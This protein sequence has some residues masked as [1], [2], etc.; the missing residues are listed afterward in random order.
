M[1]AT[2]YLKQRKRKKLAWLL[3]N[4]RMK[5]LEAREEKDAAYSIVLGIY[6]KKRMKN[7]IENMRD[8]RRE[9][10]RATSEYEESEDEAGIVNYKAREKYGYTFERMKLIERDFKVKMRYFLGAKMKYKELL[11]NYKKAVIKRKKYEYELKKL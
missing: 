7:L 10:A 1:T 8:A 4:A 2:Q 5:E 6:N 11:N 9:F 3:E